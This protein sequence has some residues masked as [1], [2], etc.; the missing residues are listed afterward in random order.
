MLSTATAFV[1]PFASVI[2]NVFVTPSTVE[3][4]GVIQYGVTLNSDTKNSV[5][6]FPITK[7]MKYFD[8]EL[9]AVG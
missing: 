6:T 3:P 4:S 5:G 1:S 2:L 8:S 9:N 7:V